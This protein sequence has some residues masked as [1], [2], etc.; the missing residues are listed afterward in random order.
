MRKSK[1]RKG[2]KK[3][4]FEDNRI[5]YIPHPNLSST[6]PLE[7]INAL[8]SSL[9]QKSTECLQTNNRHMSSKIKLQSYL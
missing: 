5:A 7:L 6:L 8:E 1:D 2:G 9:V 3:T 4:D